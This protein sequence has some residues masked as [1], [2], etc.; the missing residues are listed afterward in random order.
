MR[1]GGILATMMH[2]VILIV[3]VFCGA[4]D[5]SS[6]GK[7]ERSETVTDADVPPAK[8]AAVEDAGTC[9]GSD[10]PS[11]SCDQPEPRACTVGLAEA[12]GPGMAGLPQVDFYLCNCAGTW[13]CRHMGSTLGLCVPADGR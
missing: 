7:N 8:D 1:G 3:A 10:L 9:P 4:C 11:G 6:S 5:S 2:R 13:R 12:C